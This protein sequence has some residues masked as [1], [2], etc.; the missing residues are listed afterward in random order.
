MADTQF[1]DQGQTQ[2][3]QGGIFGGSTN[4]MDIN[5]DINIDFNV[6]CV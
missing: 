4:P 1:Q 6:R 3:S 5:T 2:S